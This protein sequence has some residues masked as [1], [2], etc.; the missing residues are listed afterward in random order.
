MD[1]TL[2]NKKCHLGK[3]EWK[4]MLT[5]SKNKFFCGRNAT[6]WADLITS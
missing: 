1:K 5:R 2:I 4:A 6:G 3:L